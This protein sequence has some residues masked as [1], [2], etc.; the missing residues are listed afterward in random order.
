MSSSGWDVRHVCPVLLS[1]AIRR[2]PRKLLL[3]RGLAGLRG[4]QKTIPCSS[5]MEVKWAW[6]Y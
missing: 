3:P 1:V 4:A 2:L 6:F 5:L